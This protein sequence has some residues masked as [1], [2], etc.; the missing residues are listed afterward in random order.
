[1]A[2]RLF[3]TLFIAGKISVT[4]ATVSGSDASS[5]SSRVRS[6]ARGACREAR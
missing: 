1:M 6:N 3:I 2:T 4:D 5:A